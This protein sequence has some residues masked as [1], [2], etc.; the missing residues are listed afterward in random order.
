MT[1]PLRIVHAAQFQLN[2]NG[3][4]YFNTDQKIQQG[5]IRLGHMSYAFSINDIARMHSPL[6]S[7]A[8]GRKAVNQAL[9]RTCRNV[10]PHLLLL[11]H[12]QSITADTLKIIR[13][14]IPDIR[15]AL[16]YVDP[17]WEPKDVA[18]I[19]DRRHLLDGIFA[20]TSGPLLDAL[21]TDTCFAKYMPNPVDPSIEC[22]RCFEKPSDQL[23]Y[24][25][26]Y[27]GSE[28]GASGRAAFIREVHDALAGELRFGTFGLLGGPPIFGAEREAILAGTKMAINL[29]RRNDVPLYSSD[30]MAQLMGN[31]ILTFCPDSTGLEETLGQ[32]SAV[33]FSDIHDLVDK[34]R[35]YHAHD[36]ERRHIANVG[37]RQVHRLWSATLVAESILSASMRPHLLASPT[38]QPLTPTS[39]T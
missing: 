35:F 1:S 19:Y 33:Y 30:R 14:E 38:G 28:S 17:L 8:L 37:W 27:I 32:E 34:V 25:L 5:L 10:R 26:T 29:S 21:A 11:G 18:H 4:R 16:W 13:N 15:I 12:A 39:P 22:H 24:D 36:V 23:D 6:K 2:K 7:K 3:S 31:G 20:T 9:V